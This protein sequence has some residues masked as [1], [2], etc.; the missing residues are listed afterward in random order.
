MLAG[1]AALLACGVVLVWASTTTSGRGEI[2]E[3]RPEVA[4]P[5]YRTDAAR[6]IDAYERLMDRY[7]DL[8]QDN[9]AGFSADMHT[10]LDKLDSIEREL[11]RL[12]A[13]VERIERSLGIV[14]APPANEKNTRPETP[15]GGATEKP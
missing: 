1:L 6:A 3:V 4:I 7:L 10:A 2:Y 12:S 14:Q 15:V 9:L 8:T 11:M 13:R 5:E